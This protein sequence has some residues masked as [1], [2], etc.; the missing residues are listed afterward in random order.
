MRKLVIAE[1]VKKAAHKVAEKAK[2]NYEDKN[3]N[4]ILVFSNPKLELFYKYGE[5]DEYENFL[6]NRHEDFKNQTKHIHTIC[7]SDMKIAVFDKQKSDYPQSIF[8]RVYNETLKSLRVIMGTE[9][10]EYIND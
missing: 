5:E 10:F 6:V 9:Y 8:E 7:V 4:S 2:K 3:F 1:N